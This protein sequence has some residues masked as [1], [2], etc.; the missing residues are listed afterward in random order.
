MQRRPATSATS[1]LEQSGYTL[2][3]ILIVLTL[4]GVLIGISWPAVLQYSSEQQL[5]RAAEN[6]RSAAASARIKAIDSGTEYQF[7]FEPGGQRYIVIP[8]SPPDNIGGNAM[9]PGLV[10]GETG[11][12][13]VLSGKLPEDCW[14][15]SP[16]QQIGQPAAA[17]QLSPDWFTFLPESFELAGTSWSAPVRFYAD[18]SAEDAWFFIDDD[19]QHRVDVAVRALTGTATTGQLQREV[20]P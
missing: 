6:V 9:Q 8:G 10:A 4:I 7:R 19:R 5:L 13:P 11:T 2:F 15:T 16:D 3:E 18:G 12:V 17:E 1:D 20:T 14:F